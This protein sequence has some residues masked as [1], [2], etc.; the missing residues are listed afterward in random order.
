MRSPRLSPRPSCHDLQGELTPVDLICWREA[1]R[2]SALLSFPFAV[3]LQCSGG[4]HTWGTFFVMSSVYK[5][6][7]VKA[8]GVKRKTNMFGK[9][10][11]AFFFFVSRSIFLAD[12]TLV[13]SA[14]QFPLRLWYWCA[15]AGFPRTRAPSRKLSST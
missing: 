4:Q 1:R 2:I 6:L 10:S 13:S 5:F 15:R 8:T 9:C 11:R 7:R 14:A 12:A 3:Q